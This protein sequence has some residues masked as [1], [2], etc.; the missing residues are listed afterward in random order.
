MVRVER[1]ALSAILLLGAV[2]AHAQPGAVFGRILEANTER[3]VANARVVIPSRAVEARS[4]SV[5]RFRFSNVEPGSFTLLI[6]AIGLDSL[7]ATVTLMAKD[8]IEA[9]FVMSRPSTKLTAVNVD[10]TRTIASWRL[11]EFEGRRKTG[12]GRFVTEA[13]FE[14]TSSRDLESVLISRVAGI[15]TRRVAGKMA[16][17]A[18]REGKVCYPQVVVNGLSVW[19]GVPAGV[20]SKSMREVLIFD[21]NSIPTAEVIGF[22]Y[23]NPS[24]TPFRYN[25]TGTGGDGSSCGTAIIWTK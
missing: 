10:A 3:P 5:G 23:H 12:F 9:E 11:D 21:I 17:T 8:Q 6:K 7:V 20:D 16:L 18:S 22:E 19:N 1:V 2:R 14:E 13:Y 25:A 15:R 4:D 24:T